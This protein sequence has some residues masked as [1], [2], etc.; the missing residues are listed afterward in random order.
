VCD[1]PSRIVARLC[2]IL[3][4]TAFPVSLIASKYPF[5]S[6]VK[7]YLCLSTVS[8]FS[9]SLIQKKNNIFVLDDAL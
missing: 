7:I 3:D 4:G 8:S 6:G 9:S 5:G 1:S 2:Q